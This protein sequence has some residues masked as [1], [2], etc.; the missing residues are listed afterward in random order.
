[1]QVSFIEMTARR[2]RFAGLKRL[3]LSLS[4]AELKFSIKVEITENLRRLVVYDVLGYD[5]EE[6]D[7]YFLGTNIGSIYLKE[8]CFFVRSQYASVQG[9][10]KWCPV[11]NTLEEI[12]YGE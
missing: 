11:D 8:L 5:I 9:R 7:V 4:V 10:W 6:E 2:Q 3:M 12:Q 1:M